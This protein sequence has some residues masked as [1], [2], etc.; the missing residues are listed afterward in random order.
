MDNA[1]RR[2]LVCVGQHAP[3][4]QEDGDGGGGSKRNAPQRRP[5]RNKLVFVDVATGAELRV[6]NAAHKTPLSAMCVSSKAD[7]A[8]T[9]GSGEYEGCKLWAF[10]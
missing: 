6:V 10:P 9:V 2:A 3:P 8:G 1:G 7:V 4:S 5:Q